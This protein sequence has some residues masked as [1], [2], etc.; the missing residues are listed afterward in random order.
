MSSKPVPLMQPVPNVVE[1]LEL[2]LAKAKTGELRTVAIA[3][4]LQGGDMF[5]AYDTDDLFILVAAVEI[6]KFDLLNAGRRV[7]TTDPRE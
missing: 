6:L 7:P 2:A 1:E 5:T 3:G 4:R